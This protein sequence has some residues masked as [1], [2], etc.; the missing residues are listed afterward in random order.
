MGFLSKIFKAVPGPHNL[1]SG[2]SGSSGG[3]GSSSSTSVTSDAQI[4]A[5]EQGQATQGGAVGK[6]NAIVL[7]TDSKL[8]IGGVELQGP[9]TGVVNIEGNAGA[10]AISNTFAATVE[11]LA[12]KQDGKPLVDPAAPAEKKSGTDYTLV[13]WVIGL[14]VTVLASIAFSRGRKST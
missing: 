1:F 13:F 5:S 3:G 12:G 7:G 8:N 14:L 11:K 4:G 2:G 6:D 10:E 9:N